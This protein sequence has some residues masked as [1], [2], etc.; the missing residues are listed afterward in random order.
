MR[1]E[2]INYDFANLYMNNLVR[3]SWGGAM[4]DYFTA[5]NGV[6][7]PIAYSLLRVC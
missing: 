4:T 6:L 3:V 2:T 5:L 1:A 7:S